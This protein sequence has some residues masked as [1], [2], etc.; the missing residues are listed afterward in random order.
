MQHLYSDR[1]QNSGW[2]N[3]AKAKTRGKVQ[4]GRIL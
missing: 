2:W 4:E 1:K 3:G